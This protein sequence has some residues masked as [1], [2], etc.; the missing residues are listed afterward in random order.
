M[1][2]VSLRIDRA[3]ASGIPCRLIEY[4]DRAESRGRRIGALLDCREMKN[5]EE[6]FLGVPPH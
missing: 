1:S 6:S 3:S 4:N 2:H 5:A